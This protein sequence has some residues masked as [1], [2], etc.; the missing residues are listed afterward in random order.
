MARRLI[1]IASEDVGLADP[2]GL[3]VTLAAREAVETIG[4]P[5]CDL[6]LA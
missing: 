1:R 3:E 5:E 2:K 4:L 6:A